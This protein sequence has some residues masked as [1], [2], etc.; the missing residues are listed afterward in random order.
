[1]QV[2]DNLNITG[3][4]YAIDGGLIKTSQSPGSWHSTPRPGDPA[5]VAVMS[6]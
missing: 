4:N 5:A 1:M 3:T 6:R 2:H